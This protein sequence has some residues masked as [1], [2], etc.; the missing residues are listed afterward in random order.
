VL[1]VQE[2]QAERVQPAQEPVQRERAERVP[3]TAALVF[4]ELALAYPEREPV[5]LE[6]R[7]LELVSPAEQLALRTI[8]VS[9]LA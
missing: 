6:L 3:P 2:E 7:A 1:V 4:L 8:S 9:E 5:E